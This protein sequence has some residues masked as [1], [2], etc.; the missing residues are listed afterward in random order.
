MSQVV[1]STIIKDG[2]N[3]ATIRLSKILKLKHLLQVSY[4]NKNNDDSH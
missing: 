3:S 2:D 1:F 4:F